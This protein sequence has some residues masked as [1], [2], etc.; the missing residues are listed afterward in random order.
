MTTDGQIRPDPEKNN[1]YR[2]DD[3]MYKITYQEMADYFIGLSNET[4]ELISNLKLQKLVYYT[5]AWFLAILKRPLFDATFKAW[6]HG[7]VIPELYHEYKEFSW[8]PIQKNIG[9]DY[10]EK[11]RNKLNEEEK[12]LLD[13]ITSEYFGVSSYD[14]ELMTHSEAPWKKA[15]IGLTDDDVSSPVIEN[16]W[17]EEY[18]SQFVYEEDKK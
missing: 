17:M 6:V 4:H 2:K 1:F 13:V 10:I 11:L 14:L 16:E 7:P 15:R 9:E 3:Y 12:H 18:Y 5:Q 8:M